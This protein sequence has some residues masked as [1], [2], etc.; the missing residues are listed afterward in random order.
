MFGIDN[1]FVFVTTGILLNLY[2]GQDTMY[3]MARS[4]SQGRLAG[5]F[6]ALGIS[7]GALF[8]T[9]I[10]ALGLSAIIMSSVH[11]FMLIKIAGACYLIFQALL[12]FKESMLVASA[13]APVKARSRL[14]TI[15]RQGALTNILNPK[16][17]LFFLA[18]LPQFISPA[19]SNKT[20]S[21]IIL[22][23]IFIFNSTLWCIL[24]ALF[25][26]FFSNKLRSNRNLSRWL[27]RFNAG[28]FCYLGLKLVFYPFNG[29]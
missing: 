27:L 21:F 4:I 20:L 17:A 16:V 11:A 12:M 22:G 1:F 7:T 14:I 3:I 8:H 29:K 13:G 25:A 26:A 19:S 28:L 9:L 10:G 18:L 23:L 5:V 15:F 6:A 2:P 24:V